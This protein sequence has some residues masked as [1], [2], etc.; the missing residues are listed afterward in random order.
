[1]WTA[2]ALWT[3]TLGGVALYASWARR[4]GRGGRPVAWPF[5]VGVPLVYFARVRCVHAH[6]LRDGV[7]GARR[8]RREVRIGVGGNAAAVLATSTARSSAPRRG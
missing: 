1:M 7:A 5:V 4:R 6:L 8:G 3:V 2:V